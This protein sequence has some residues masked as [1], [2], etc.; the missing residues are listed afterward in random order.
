MALRLAL[1]CSWKSPG[2]RTMFMRLTKL[3]WMYFRYRILQPASRLLLRHWWAIAWGKDEKLAERYTKCQLLVNVSDYDV[4]LHLLL[5]QHYQQEM[6]IRDNVEP[7]QNTVIITVAPV[8]PFQS[9]HWFT[10]EPMRVQEMFGHSL[11]FLLD[12]V[13]SD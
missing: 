3:L 8:Q 1:S 9:H 13:W 6:W 10:S 5:E 4:C 11:L 12:H 7:I 2:P